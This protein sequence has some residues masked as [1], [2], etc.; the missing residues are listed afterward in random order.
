MSDNTDRA[1]T[2]YAAIIRELIKAA[3]RESEPGVPYVTAMRQAYEETF[4]RIDFENHTVTP[5]PGHYPL[6]DAS[7]KLAMVALGF[8]NFLAWRK[9][10]K[11]NDDFFVVESDH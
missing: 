4:R 11:L 2:F 8:G 5:T 9:T 6:D 7:F 3:I 1:T 10:F